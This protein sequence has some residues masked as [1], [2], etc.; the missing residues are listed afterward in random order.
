M[1][2]TRMT[3]PLPPAATVRSAAPVGPGERLIAVVSRWRERAHQRRQLASLDERLLRDVGLTR[4]QVEAEW[5]K[6]FWRA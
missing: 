3:T 5:R 6:P 2:A 1:S 4:F